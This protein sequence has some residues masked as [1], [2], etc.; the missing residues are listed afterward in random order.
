L[1]SHI[2]IAALLNG[3]TMAMA[4]LPEEIPVALSTF[5][6]LGAIPDVE[7]SGVGKASAND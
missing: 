2:I 1:K 6:A 3:L 7:K 5:M 4:I